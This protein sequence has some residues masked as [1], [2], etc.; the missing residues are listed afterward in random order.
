MTIILDDWLFV[1]QDQDYPSYTNSI[2]DWPRPLLILD[3][4]SQV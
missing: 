3:L 2:I 1:N 4:L